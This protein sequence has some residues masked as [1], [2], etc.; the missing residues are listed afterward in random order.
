MG[1]NFEGGS[2]RV[3]IGPLDQPNPAKTFVLTV[4]ALIILGA[5]AYLAF[6]AGKRPPRESPPF[7]TNQI[8]KMKLDD[9]KVMVVR[10]SYY[11]HGWLCTVRYPLATGEYVTEQ[12]SCWEMEILGPGE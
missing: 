10:T 8:V 5:V 12:F 1:D 3:G 11:A 9:R 6:F 4:A 2:V 7:G